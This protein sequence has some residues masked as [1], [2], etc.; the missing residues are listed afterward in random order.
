M[1]E[2]LLTLAIDDFLTSECKSTFCKEGR[3][4]SLNGIQLYN[5]QNDPSTLPFFQLFDKMYL[6]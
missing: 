5:L 4:K 1:V 6:F 3:V 2:T